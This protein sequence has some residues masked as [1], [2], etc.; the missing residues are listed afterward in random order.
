MNKQQNDLSNYNPL[1]KKKHICIIN[2]VQL[3]SNRN[4]L[5]VNIKNIR[6]SR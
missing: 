4:S 3:K 2:I 6:H 5:G 1:F